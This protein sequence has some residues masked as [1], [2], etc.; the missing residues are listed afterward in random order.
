MTKIKTVAIFTIFEANNIGAYLQA[1]SLMTVVK[2]MGIE[3]VYIGKNIQVGYG[4]HN[5]SIFAKVIKYL[6]A[7]DIKKLMFKSRSA[8]VYRE[9]QSAIPMI[10]MAENPKIDC[11]II[12]SDEVWNIKSKNFTHYS[13]YFGHGINTDKI[14]AY[15][16]CGNGVTA[17]DFHKIMP[18]EKFQMFSSLS[19]RDADTQLCVKIVSGKEVTRVVDPTML[20]DDFGIEFPEC[21]IHKD[22]I[23]VYSYG[24]DDKYISQIRRFAKQKSMPLISVGTYN[25]WC[26]K[27]VIVNPWEFLGYLK[28]A[29][30]VI[31]STFHG[32]ILSIK[33]NKQ[34]VCYAGNSSK[35]QDVLKF[36]NLQDRNVRKAEELTEM[37]NTHIDYEPVNHI[38]EDSRKDSVDYLKNAM[39]I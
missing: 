38:I 14:I 21:P 20:I 32:T 35:V 6:K 7:G 31:V 29:K 37:F 11:A 39:G 9:M 24:I 2:R 36:Y 30:Y 1:Y 28:A 18:D 27:N 15:A 13:T 26:N 23:M 25:S 22:F 4:S 33:L 10:D 17:D 12:G 5:S 8:A 34:F 19:S 3:N 16:P